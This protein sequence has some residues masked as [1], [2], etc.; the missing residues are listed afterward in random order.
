MTDSTPH[1][2]RRR[3]TGYR[4]L[5]GTVQPLASPIQDVTRVAHLVY[6]DHVQ[7]AGRTEK[8]GNAHS[9]DQVPCSPKGFT[10]SA[11][12]CS[13]IKSQKSQEACSG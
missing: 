9:C 3:S 4:G 11:A 8:P 7:I 5:R 12:A 6:G 10:V 1:S 2:N 13:Q